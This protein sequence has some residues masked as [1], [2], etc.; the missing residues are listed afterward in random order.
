MDGFYTIKDVCRLL[1]VAR[2]TLRRWEDQE[3]SFPKRTRLS[4]HARGRAG[5]L[6]REIDEWIVRRPR[7]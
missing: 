3:P 2:E 4:R 1:N 6:R 5:Y 7:A